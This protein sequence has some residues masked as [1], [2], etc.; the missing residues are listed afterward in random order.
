M[1]TEGRLGRNPLKGAVGD[2]M[3]ALLCG[4]GHNLRL[5]LNY[6]RAFFVWLWTMWVVKNQTVQRTGKES[7]R[8]M[9]A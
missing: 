6:L 8:W 5:I 7:M 4:A 9:A 1:K 3:H 2:A